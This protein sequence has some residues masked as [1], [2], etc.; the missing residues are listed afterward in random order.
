VPRPYGTRSRPDLRKGVEPQGMSHV[1]ADTLSRMVTVPPV[2]PAVTAAREWSRQTIQQWR[3]GEAAEPIEHLV[4][5]LVTNSVEHAE[6]VSVT[7]LLTYAA[8][9]LRLEVGDQDAAHVPVLKCPEPGDAGG[10]G[11]VIVQAMSDRWG[12]EV[13]DSG[14]AVWCEFALPSSVP[15][16]GH[17]ALQGRAGNGG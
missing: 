11:L 17:G 1:Q 3:L 10:R 2:P 14:K 16:A 12:V 9:V 13:T 8:D 7:V 15:P 5:E 6:C 4:S